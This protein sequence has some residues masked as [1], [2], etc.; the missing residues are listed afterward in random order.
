MDKTNTKHFNNDLKLWYNHPAHGAGEDPA[1]W[2]KGHNDSWDRALPVGNGSLGAMIFGGTQLE[3][4]QLNVESLWSGGPQE[5]DN[6]DALVYLPEIR[7][8]LFEHKY[9]E[10]QKLA[11][12][13]LVCAGPGSKDGATGDFGCYQTLGDLRFIFGNHGETSEYRRELDI[14]TAIATVKYR[15]NDA[16]FTREIFVSAPDQ[17]LVVRITCNQHKMISFKTTIDREEHYKTTVENKN[18]LVMRGQLPGSAKTQFIARLQVSAQGA[19]ISGQDNSIDV[20][21]ADSVTLVLT[22]ATNFKCKEFERITQQQMDSVIDRPYEDL[23][24]RHIKEYQ[25]YFHSVYL[26][27]GMETGMASRLPTDERLEAIKNGASDPQ[28]IALYFQYGR[29]LLISSSR[30]GCLPAN[31]QGIWAAQI[32]TPWNGDYHLNINTQ[33]NYWLAETTNLA[34]CHLPL[35]DLIESLVEPGKKTARIHYNTSGWVVHT[36]TNIWGFTSPGEHPGWG[37]FPAAGGWLCEHLWEHYA[38]TEDKDFLLRAYPIMKESAQFYMDFL[39]IDPR[40]GWLVTSPSSSPENKFRTADGQVASV[41][42]G[43]SMDMEIIRELFTNCIKAS[44]ILGRDEDFRSVLTNALEHL[45]PLQTGKHGQLMEWVEDFDEPE[46]GHR[47]LSHLYAL[48]PASQI[49]MRQTPKLAIAARKSLERRLSSGGGHTGWSRAWIIN[50]WARLENGEKAYENILALLSHSTH[51]NLLDN[52]PP[53]QIDGN[54]GA[55]AG[56]AEMLLQSHAGEISLLPA[57]PKQWPDGNISGLCARGGFEIDIEWRAGELST[58]KLKSKR[59]NLC[60][61]RSRM[62]LRV[63]LNGTEI[64][65]QKIEAAVLEFRTEKGKVYSIAT[66]D[67]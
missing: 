54:F 23:R 58:A 62:L 67:I 39:V 1:T 61:I 56:I 15:I 32:Q 55:T 45:V 37:Q 40:S 7:R 35:F 33:M 16:V 8:L 30:P 14:D 44:E 3:R 64:Q 43:P 26:N 49:T 48:Y 36:I 59:G 28:L 11:Y 51:Q 5:A 9:V 29:Y 60:R 66:S 22:A 27:L 25:S 20:K 2:A 31:L 6:P 17:A 53:F 41:C 13:K 42:Y 52:H 24:S 34:K 12:E 38:F 65:T 10:A 50:F 46:P 4:I 21:N 47:H 63:Y 19:E 18:R 57:L